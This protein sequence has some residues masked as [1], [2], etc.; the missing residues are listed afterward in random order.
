MKMRSY[1]LG[2]LTWVD[3]E[4]F[5]TKHNVVIVPVGSCEQHGPHLPMDTDAYDA[6]W[7]SMKAAEKAQ[8]ALV[9]PPIYYG[10]SSH[11]MD[12]PGTVTLTP[13][14]LEQLAYEVACSLTKHGFKKIL[15]ENGHGGNTPA[16]EAAA[17]RIKTDTNAFV[18]ID[19]VS[20][21]PDFI[22][23]HIETPYDAHAGE[24]ET[25][26]TLANRE[27]FI[28]KERIKKPRITLPKSKYT[29]IGLKET[30]PKVSWSFKTKEISET[31]VIGDPTKATKKKGEK[32]WK[33]GIERLADLLAEL[34]K[35]KL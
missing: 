11:H 22:E 34:D 26:T 32:A 23:K 20:L 4:E 17:Q 12:F 28:V 19:T 10:V 16:L 35:M 3:V 24:F 14:T 25:S 18:A 15:F 29:K 7:L 5:L 30:G 31:G 33:L 27:N 21:I 2:E 9:A 6:L 13:Q 1:Y 8:C